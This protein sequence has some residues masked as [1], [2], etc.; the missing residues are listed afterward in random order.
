MQ[1]GSGFSLLRRMRQPRFALLLLVYDIWASMP[2]LDDAMAGPPALHFQVYVGVHFLLTF[3]WSLMGFHYWD[4]CTLVFKILLNYFLWKYNAKTMMG[5]KSP[6]VKLQSVTDPEIPVTI[7]DLEYW[8][9][10]KY[11]KI[12]SLCSSH[13]PTM[14]ALPWIWFQCTSRQHCK[15]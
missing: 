13:L 7:D 4:I 8:E 5:Q 11:M 15:K 10:S 3:Y 9:M 1:C 14:V 2:S 12:L 6:I